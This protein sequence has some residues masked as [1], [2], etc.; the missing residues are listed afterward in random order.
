MG[1]LVLPA[2][3]LVYLDTQ[4]VIY[5]VEKHP[6]YGPL[7]LPLWQAVQAGSLDVA[8]SDLAILEALIGPLRTKNQPLA[9]YY[10]QFF[11]QLGVR[12]LPISVSILKDAA[13]LRADKKLRTPDA[14]HASTAIAIGAD[15]F[16]TNDRRL[17]SVPSLPVTVLSEI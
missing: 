11:A 16:L 5:T 7:L 9:T 1:Q 6:V 10:D 15:M 14:I 12:M 13:R 4:V 3:G 8:C 17:K 2:A